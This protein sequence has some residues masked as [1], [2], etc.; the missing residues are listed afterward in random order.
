VFHLQILGVFEIGGIAGGDAFKG[1]GCFGNK[2]LSS[3]YR[4]MEVVAVMQDVFSD[5]FQD[6]PGGGVEAGNELVA[7]EVAEAGGFDVEVV[8]GVGGFFAPGADVGGKVGFVRH[9]VG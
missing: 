6:G 8:A 1:I 3:L 5:A 2:P 4:R 7:V 9:L